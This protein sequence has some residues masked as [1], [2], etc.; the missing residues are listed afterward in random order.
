[1]RSVHS[2]SKFSRSK[3]QR[4]ERTVAK[5]LQ[6][7]LQCEVTRELSA[8][9]DG[10]CD[11]KIQLGDITYLVEVKFH[12]KV[13]QSIISGWWDQA[14]EQSKLQEK[15]YMNPIPILIYKQTHWKQWE[16]R[17]PWHHL[18]W[19]MAKT[20]LKRPNFS[21]ETH[22]MTVP[23]DILMDIMKVGRTPTISKGKMTTTDNNDIDRTTL[24]VQP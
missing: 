20:A 6:A 10:G 12:T 9:R 14:I 7:G 13:S 19:Q 3:G 16:C 8:S 24:G 1:M 21:V 23:I 22:Y 11:I 17:M 5:L 18:L 4:G 2:M 15:T